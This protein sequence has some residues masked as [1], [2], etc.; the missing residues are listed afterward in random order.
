VVTGGWWLVA[1]ETGDSSELLLG[2]FQTYQPPTTS[3]QNV[4]TDAIVVLTTVASEDEAVKLVRTLLERR[5]VACGTLF[6]GARSL[7]R[8]QSKIAD[9]REVVVLLKTRSARLDSL[10]S[11]FNE[12]HPYKVPELLALPVSAGLGKYLEW[13]NGETSLAL[14]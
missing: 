14:A 3:H 12:L 9:E 1:G 13:I 11:A 2:R 8:W 6:P 10:Q 5:L 4:H 7:Y